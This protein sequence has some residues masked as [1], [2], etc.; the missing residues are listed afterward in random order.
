MAELLSVAAQTL[1]LVAL[2]YY[3]FRGMQNLITFENE[4]IGRLPVSMRLAAFF[5]WWRFPK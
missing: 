3:V 4:T 5:L 2:I 1:F